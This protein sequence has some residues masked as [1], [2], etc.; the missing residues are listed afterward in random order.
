MADEIYINTGTTFQQPYQGQA[1]V[2]AQSPETKQATG[3]TPAQARQPLTYNNRQPV[4]YR[5]PAVQQSPFIRNA[6]QPFNYTVRSPFTYQHR[7]P[8]TYSAQQANPYIADSQTPFTYQ[9]PANKQSPFTYQHRSPF[10]YRNPTNAQQPV[11]RNAQ[12]SYQSPSN[13]QQPVPTIGQTPYTYQSPFIGRT[14][15][16]YIANA[17]SPYNARQPAA[18]IYDPLEQSWGPSAS[19]GYWATTQSRASTNPPPEVGCSMEFSNATAFS[20]IKALWFGY[21]NQFQATV[22][23]DY[24]LYQGLLTTSS[25]FTVKYDVGGQSCSGKDCNSSY[26]YSS[27]G[28]LPTNAGYNSGTYYSVP[29][30]GA[31]QFFWKACV[32]PNGSNPSGTTWVQ[33]QGVSF[34]VKGVDSSNNVYTTTYSHGNISLNATYGMVLGV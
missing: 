12:Q 29:T 18:Y 9:I 4:T 30:S 16:P 22:Y 21:T 20:S 17:R 7:S 31:R 5:T 32:T 3:R 23:S 26:C 6:Q 8:F 19:T 27:I 25:T 10:T 15:Y 24:I 34:T 11:I 1:V 13:A 2:N 28:P 33:A 14:P